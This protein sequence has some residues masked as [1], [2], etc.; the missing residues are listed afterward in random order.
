MVNF[1]TMKPIQFNFFCLRDVSIYFG[2]IISCNEL[3]G[4]IVVC[5]I[6]QI[7]MT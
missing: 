1:P 6:L 4:F 5:V 2:K 7:K 3:L